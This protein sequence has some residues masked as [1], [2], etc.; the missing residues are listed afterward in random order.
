MI[1]LLGKL[2]DLVLR[3]LD[4]RRDTAKARDRNA[5]RKAVAEHDAQALNTLIQERKDTDD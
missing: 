3:W 4:W 2:L 1:S 5:A